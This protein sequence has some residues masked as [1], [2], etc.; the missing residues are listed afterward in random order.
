MHEGAKSALVYTFATIFSR[1]LAIITVPIFTRLMTTEQIGIVNLYNSWYSLLSVVATLSLTSGGFAVAMKEFEGE[2]DQYLSSVL[3]L[4]S[5]IGLVIGI[6]FFFLS[7]FWTTITGLS[8][9]LLMLMAIGFVVAPARDFWLA[10]QRY[11][12]KYKLAGGLT[13]LS[14]IVASFVS[15]LA[16]YYAKN[17]NITDGMVVAEYRLVSN[18]IVIYGIAAVIWVF[19]FLKGKTLFNLKYWKLSLSLSLPLIG[20]AIASQ[21]LSVSDRMMISKMVN[22]SAVGIY[23]TLYTV[24][25]LSLMVWTAINASFVPY[26]YQN[27]NVNN[28]KIKEISFSLLTLYSFVAIVLV[29]LAPEIVKMLATNEYYEAIYIMPPIAGGVFFIAVSNMF[30]NVLIFLK[31]TKYIMF[32]A[33]IA[34]TL[35]LIT[36]Y[37]FIDIYG[38]MAASYTT[39]FSYI[40]MT[41]CLAIFAIKCGKR[42][43]L[44]VS[45]F[46]ANRKIGFLSVVTLGFCLS[47]MILYNYKIIR[48]IIIVLIIVIG[49]VFALC[50]QKKNLISKFVKK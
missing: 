18:Y 6:F 44:K 17:N 20:Y 42:N 22:D 27:I 11:E 40:I 5:A 37:I 43:N 45:D 7:T 38:Y 1:G 24:S 21:I 3:T 15:I 36:N 25:S 34:A 32:S 49:I 33:F 50:L 4:T 31:K 14:A 26:L 9:L 35:N 28:K 23:S 13:I 8:K 48:Y 29:Y 41:I 39:L 19:L 2:R 10:R 30:S 47:G 46:Y 12:Y 16:V